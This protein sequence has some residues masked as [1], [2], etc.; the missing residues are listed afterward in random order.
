[1][2]SGAAGRGPAAKRTTPALDRRSRA[3]RPTTAPP[4]PAAERRKRQTT[5]TARAAILVVALAAVTLAV[6]LPFKI[7]LGQRN[8]ITSLS[9]QTVQTQHQITALR[10]QHKRWQE[11]SYI[12]QQARQRLHLVMPGQKTYV[13]LGNKATHKSRSTATATAASTLPWYGQLWSSVRAAGAA[14]PAK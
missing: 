9:A 8:D 5:L 7:W 12:E 6:A 14:A 11:P 4:R 10:A 3:P 2:R 13:V 1:M